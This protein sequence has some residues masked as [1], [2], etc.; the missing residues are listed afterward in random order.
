MYDLSGFCKIQQKGMPQLTISLGSTKPAADLL[1]RASEG[2]QKRWGGAFLVT[3]TEL[4]SNLF[5][6]MIPELLQ[7]FSEKKTKTVW[8]TC[9]QDPCCAKD[10]F[11]FKKRTG[12][13]FLNESVDG[14]L[15][16]YLFFQSKVPCLV[17]DTEL[18]NKKKIGIL[19]MKTRIRCAFLIERV[20]CEIITVTEH[21]RC[22]RMLKQRKYINLNWL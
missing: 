20:Y 1:I 4:L 13:N 19:K 5:I 21:L 9:S 7:S 10:S 2:A 6:S 18:L 15:S 3:E 22:M 12:N 16:F 17:G 14:A 8:A 11:Q